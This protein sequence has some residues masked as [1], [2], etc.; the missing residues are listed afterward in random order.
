MQEYISWD[1]HQNQV[2]EKLKEQPLLK[3]I[4]LTTE[5]KT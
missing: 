5:I 4:F 2:K 3:I 1:T